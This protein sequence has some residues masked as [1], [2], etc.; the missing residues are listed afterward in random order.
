MKPNPGRP[1]RRQRARTLVAA[2]AASLAIPASSA[3]AQSD[4]YWGPHMWGNW[5]WFFGP[6]MM[7]A[8]LVLIVFLT[9]LSVRWLG[10]VGTG[11]GVRAQPEKTALDMLRERFARGEIDKQEFE[12]RRRTLGT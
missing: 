10:G 7:L 2:V 5:G 3:F 9:A 4:A 1:L 8:V 6:F 11:G 12:D